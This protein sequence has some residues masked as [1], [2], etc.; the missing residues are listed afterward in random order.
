MSYTAR[1]GPLGKLGLLTALLAFALAAAAVPPPAG[2]S[3]YVFA[4]VEHTPDPCAETL[5]HCETVAVA[6]TA[7]PQPLDFGA[8]ARTRFSAPPLPAGARRVPPHGPASLSILFRNL[9]E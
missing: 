1:M 7:H 8:A 2:A 6:A 4:A 3:S 5:R 9:R